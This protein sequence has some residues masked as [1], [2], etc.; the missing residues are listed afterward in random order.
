MK[1]STEKLSNPVWNA[2][3]ETHKKFVIDYD[4]VRF[5]K[6]EICPFGAFMN[7][8]KTKEAINYYAKLTDSF[9]IVGNEPVHDSRVFLNKTVPCEQMI[10]NTLNEPNYT[11]TI[12]KL[13]T[14]HIEEL[15]EL[16]WLVMPG[17]YKKRTFEMGDY[18]G[19]F[20]N[21][22]LVAATGERLQLDNFIE[23]SAVV[24]HPNH[25]RKGLAKQLVA[26][27]AKQ[28]IEKGKIP[29]LH[30]AE[31]NLGAI[32]LYKKLGFKSI[33]KMVWRHYLKR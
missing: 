16:V 18:Y 29:I 19:I 23:I 30:V 26:Y 9:F 17:Y 5:Y 2:L 22:K 6:P 13:T 11:H 8:N 27:T 31:N 21:N 7:L 4:G 10:V 15:Y 12:E 3:N 33:R 28:I 20:S 32:E 24:T 14:H 25:T 1:K